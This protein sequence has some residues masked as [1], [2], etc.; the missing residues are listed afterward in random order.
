[1]PRDPDDPYVRAIAPGKVTAPIVGGNLFTFVHLI[2]T[3]WEPDLTGAILLLEEVDEPPYVIDVHL[4]Q[5]RLAGKL[6]QVAGVVVGELK[7][8]DW[9]EERPEAPRTRS[10]EDVLEMN[11]GQLGVPVLYKLPLGHG[12]HLAT[13]PLGVKATLDA[14]QARLT[15]EQSGVEAV[16]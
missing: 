7:N 14:D 3:P 11:L 16:A 5:L 9:R 2:G 10:I 8:C 4:N 1:V 13:I 12:K 6:D 15:I